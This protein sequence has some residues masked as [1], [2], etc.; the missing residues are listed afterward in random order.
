M[1]K[2]C[3]IALSPFSIGEA[4]L[5]RAGRDVDAWLATPLAPFARTEA[6]SVKAGTI[7]LVMSSARFVARGMIVLVRWPSMEVAAFLRAGTAREIA[8]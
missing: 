5:V 1:L 2:S 4:M 7:A 3:S 6:A 8:C